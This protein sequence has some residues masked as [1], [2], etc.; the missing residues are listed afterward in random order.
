MTYHVDS[1]HVCGSLL[2]RWRQ[3]RLGRMGLAVLLCGVLLLGGCSAAEMPA[4]FSGAFGQTA[5]GASAQAGQSDLPAVS[6]VAGK[7][8]AR[9]KNGWYDFDDAAFVLR[10]GERVNITLKSK[11]GGNVTAFQGVLDKAGQ[12][13]V[14]CPVRSGPPDQRILCGSL[15]ALD[16]DL[17]AGIKRTFD[18]P[19]AVR[20]AT[21][22][23]ATE[24]SHLLKL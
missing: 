12:K 15:Y 23:C 2:S 10:D 16:D 7:G 11:R 1:G 24:R 18:I 14:F 6:C 4:V 17:D 20:G 19:D 22:S 8:A 5:A 13:M 3:A 21:I 9:F